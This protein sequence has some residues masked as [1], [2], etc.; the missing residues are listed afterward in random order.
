MGQTEF[1]IQELDKLMTDLRA[2]GV[3]TPFILAALTEIMVK[4]AKSEPSLSLDFNGLQLVE[5]FVD[6]LSLVLDHDDDV[7]VGLPGLLQLL[8]Q[9]VDDRAQEGLQ[10]LTSLARQRR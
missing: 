9:I 7:L 3:D 1:C 5:L 4:A 8:D 2:Q 6:A 10:V